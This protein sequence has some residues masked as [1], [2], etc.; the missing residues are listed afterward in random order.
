MQIQVSAGEVIVMVEVVD[1]ATIE[2]GGSA[3]QAVDFIT[4]IQELLS[5]IGAILTGH[6]GNKGPLRFHHAHC[7]LGRRLTVNQPIFRCRLEP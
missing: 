1:P 6:P 5:H 4:L 7:S 2:T 3:N